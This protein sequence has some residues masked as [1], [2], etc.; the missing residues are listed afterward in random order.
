MCE[1]TK[2]LTLSAQDLRRKPL[3]PP[4]WLGG[5]AQKFVFG[6]KVIWPKKDS[7]LLAKDTPKNAPVH[8]DVI[9]QSPWL[10]CDNK[11]FDE[12]FNG[13]DCTYMDIYCSDTPKWTSWPPEFSKKNARGFIQF[14]KNK[15]RP[16]MQ[17]YAEV[18]A[19]NRD[20]EGKTCYDRGVGLQTSFFNDIGFFDTGASIFDNTT[21][22]RTRLSFYTEDCTVFEWCHQ[23]GDFYAGVPCNQSCFANFDNHRNKVIVQIYFKFGIKRYSGRDRGYLSVGSFDYWFEAT[24][25]YVKPMSSRHP[26]HRMTPPSNSLVN[27]S[28]VNATSPDYYVDSNG[29]FRKKPR[30]YKTLE[31]LRERKKTV[32]TKANGA[33]ECIVCQKNK[34]II[35]LV[36]CKHVCF[37][38]NCGLK[39]MRANPKCPECREEV[40]DVLRIFI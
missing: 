29:A 32:D 19:Q 3:V 25:I 26:L 23:R 17:H 10:V 24:E 22:N 15:V 16:R 4:K 13:M 27:A 31:D 34:A 28:L 5:P 20:E 12:D 39:A 11:Q 40:P 7:I 8:S 6:Q 18:L 2:T 1:L 38:A 35:M 33:K 14:M 21:R 30:W 37:C 36:I 9:L